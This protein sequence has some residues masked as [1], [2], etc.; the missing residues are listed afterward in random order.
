MG[1][2]IGL[3]WEKLLGSPGRDQVKSLTKLMQWHSASHIIIFIYKS[4][5]ATTMQRAKLIVHLVKQLHCAHV[6]LGYQECLYGWVGGFLLRFLGM[7]F[8]HLTDTVL[9]L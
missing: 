5:L 7:M 4:L 9:H 2:V 3:I 1:H 8:L 6:V